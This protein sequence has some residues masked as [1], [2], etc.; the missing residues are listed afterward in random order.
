ME[1]NG[2]QARV[3]TQNH[4]DEH[5]KVILELSDWSLVTSTVFIPTVDPSGWEEM[6]QTS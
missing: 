4:Q 3:P 6:G 2:E 1:P 5:R